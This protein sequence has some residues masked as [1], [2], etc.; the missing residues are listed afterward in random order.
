MK[1]W[2]IHCGTA[3]MSAAIIFIIWAANT[4]QDYFFFGWCKQIPYGDKLAHFLLIGT[5]TLFLNL[6]LSNRR[7]GL[8]KQQW[9]LGSLLVFV[10]ITIE[11]A[12]QQFLENRSLDWRDLAANYLGILLFSWLALIIG[13]VPADRR[14][15]TA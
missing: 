7:I 5:V 9:L 2:L 12:S 10:G 6:S 8:L 1:R 11:E 14:S 13:S 3:A 4:G 15:P